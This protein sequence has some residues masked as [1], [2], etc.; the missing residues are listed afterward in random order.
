MFLLWSW[1]IEARQPPAGSL[2]QPVKFLRDT[3][4]QPLK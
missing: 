3:D 4:A 2:H 1:V